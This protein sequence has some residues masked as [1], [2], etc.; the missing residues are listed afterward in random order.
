MQL[1]TFRRELARYRHTIIDAIDSIGFNSLKGNLL[2]KG[3][4]LLAVAFKKGPQRMA[5]W[6]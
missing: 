5:R 6:S 2:H 4:S 3:V 1:D